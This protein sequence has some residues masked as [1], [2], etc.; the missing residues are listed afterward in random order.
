MSAV[1]PPRDPLSRSA[2]S[3][4]PAHRQQHATRAV[5]FLPGVAI[6]A[7]APLVP[8]AKA[9]TGLDEGSLGLALLCV[10]AGSLLAMPLA[11]AAAA[12]LGCRTVMLATLLLTCAALPLLPLAPSAWMLGAALFVFGAGI[13]ACDCVMNLQAVIVERDAARPMMSGFHA[14]YSIGGAVGAA[15]MTG[16]LM[17]GLPPWLAAALL[18][19]MMLATMGMAAPHWRRDRAAAGAPL[20]ALPRGIVLLIG[21]LCFVAFLGEGVMLD[22][23]AVFLHEV[24][25]VAVGHAGLGF[26]VFSVAMTVTRLFGDAAVARLGPPH[27]ILLGALIG[28]GGFV[29]LLSGLPLP[30]T[31]GGCLLIGVG[32]ANIV[33]VLFSMAGRQTDLPS[34]LAIPAVTTFG[35]AGV[36]AGPALIGLVAQASS[37]VWA[38]GL[39]AGALV[40][41]GLGARWIRLPTP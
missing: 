19:A 37:L 24:R 18:V 13:G 5:F 17:L 8:F 28:A 40:L 12:R 21:V 33:P 31:L 32:C 27:A 38:L 22:W 10:G 4:G 20:F 39:V 36:L 35:Y 7:W 14:W 23:S 25:G 11:G 26:L 1:P 34:S 16:L 6:A 3:G 41:V 30:W 2:P 9:R 29:L 15:A